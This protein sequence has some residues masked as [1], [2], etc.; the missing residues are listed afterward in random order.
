MSLTL[1]VEKLVHGGLGLART[2]EGVMLVPG[3]LPGEHV[4]ALPCGR[5]HGIAVAQVRDIIEQSPDRRV[6]P[7]PHFGHC[8]GCD[9]LFID[10]PRQISLKREI[11]LES[12]QRI[13]KL[14][15]IP[16]PD[17][18]ASPEF[19]YR[20]RVQLK[21][22]DAKAVGFFK[23]ES[24]EVVAV[25]R[26]PLLAERL[27]ALMAHVNETPAAL[28]KGLYNLRVIDGDTDIA[29]HP[30]LP[31]I[32]RATT[33]IT[34]GSRSFE[35]GGAD[36]FQGNR[37]L[38]EPMAV[39]AASHCGHG[40]TMADLY[41]G[42][43]FFSLMLA[44]SFEKVVLIESD[45]EMVRRAKGNCMR[46]AVGNISAFAAEVESMEDRLPPQLDVLIAD[47]PRPGLSP[48][49]REAIARCA[50]GSIIYVSCNCATQARDCGFLVKKAGY[51]ITAAALIDCYPNT[52]HTESIVL[53]KKEGAAP[54]RS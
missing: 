14:R 37:F 26:C 31:G 5:R 15:D 10:Y 22:D 8:G 50:P 2:P 51:S 54:S 41:G 35:V 11:F 7:C 44:G 6:P 53:L 34:C 46:N 27:N 24:N 39:W 23:R 18:I 33:A 3:V 30:V 17:V 49:A 29:S 32:T 42:T 40:G 19:G 52:H 9:W 16:A 12:M 1:T 47:P 38:L 45:P 48:K 28:P 36:F 21:I 4:T 20:R 13:G 25:G 43:G